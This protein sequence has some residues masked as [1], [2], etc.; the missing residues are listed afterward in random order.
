M[1]T[2]QLCHQV[3]ITNVLKLPQ[4]MAKYV[5]ATMHTFSLYFLL[6][7][8]MGESKE[9]SARR[10]LPSLYFSKQKIRVFLL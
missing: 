4:N 1:H 7:L 9:M 2:M 10:G 5:H 8:F 3:L 6:F